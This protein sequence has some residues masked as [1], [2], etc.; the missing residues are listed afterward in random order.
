[1]LGRVSRDAMSTIAM[2][3]AYRRFRRRLYDEQHKDED[4]L[5]LLGNMMDYMSR[6]GYDQECLVYWPRSLVIL[7]S[8]SCV[9]SNAMCL[10]R[11]NEI[12]FAVCP[13]SFTATH[14]HNG[15]ACCKYCHFGTTA[16]Y[17]DE[18]FIPSSFITNLFEAVKSHRRIINE[19]EQQPPATVAPRTIYTE[20]HTI[21]VSMVAALSPATPRNTYTH[22]RDNNDF[23]NGYTMTGTLDGSYR[24]DMRRIKGFI[25]VSPTGPPS[26]PYHVITSSSATLRLESYSHDSSTRFIEICIVLP[27][28]G[29]T[30]QRTIPY[31]ALHHGFPL[32]TL[33]DG[34]DTLECHVKSNDTIIFMFNEYHEANSFHVESSGSSDSSQCR[35][36]CNVEYSAYSLWFKEG[37]SLIPLNS[38]I[39]IPDMVRDICR[40]RSRASAG[41]APFHG[42][43][44]VGIPSDM[45]NE[46]FDTKGSMETYFDTIDLIARIK[47]TDADTASCIPD[48]YF[49]NK[50]LAVR[51]LRRHCDR[52]SRPST[53]FIGSASDTTSDASLLWS[54]FYNHRALALF[55]V[56]DRSVVF[57]PI[58]PGEQFDVVNYVVY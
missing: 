29:V 22:C 11:T 26:S 53:S 30:M 31:N 8:L 46:R 51:Q 10:S 18:E 23:I 24:L 20:V 44:P 9:V 21:N 35:C 57:T 36:R 13:L 55:K 2:L 50:A 25:G 14:Q 38:N 41:G 33:V 6:I 58:L 27:G 12:Q 3:E 15:T 54:I 52:R 7:A 39:G 49:T 48:F 19:S 37:E 43:I 47:V 34:T 56:I 5:L 42:V 40:S 28:V 45:V 16:S 4:R 17:D 32:S 1:M